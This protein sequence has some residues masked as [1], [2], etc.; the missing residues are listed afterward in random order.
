M[1]VTKTRVSSPGGSD[2]F[3]AEDITRKMEIINFLVKIRTTVLLG[4]FCVK[5]NDEGQSFGKT[6]KDNRSFS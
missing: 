3:V 6:P 1:D 4:K 2:H 5:T